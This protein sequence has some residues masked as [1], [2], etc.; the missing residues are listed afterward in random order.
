MCVQIVPQNQII[1]SILK[2]EHVIGHVDTDLYETETH[3]YRVKYIHGIIVTG[4]PVAQVVEEVQN[5]VL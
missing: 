1:L 3:A 4:A 5:T 2:L